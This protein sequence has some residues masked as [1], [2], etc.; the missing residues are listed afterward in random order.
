M[1]ALLGGS[2]L[3]PALAHAQTTVEEI[4]VTAQ[5]RE[6]KLETTPMTINVVSG[7]QIENRPS[8]R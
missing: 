2:M 6:T 4:T 7:D 5:K 1:V 3:T 8:A